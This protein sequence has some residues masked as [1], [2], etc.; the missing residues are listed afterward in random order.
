VRKRIDQE[1]EQIKLDPFPSVD[2]LYTDIG[3]TKQHYVRGVEYG[4]SQNYE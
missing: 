1:V 3:V 4:L 2:Q